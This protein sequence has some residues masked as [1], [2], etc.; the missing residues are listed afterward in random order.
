[1]YYWWT[2]S[3]C[4]GFFPSN[5]HLCGITLLLSYLFQCLFSFPDKTEA[6]PRSS[7]LWGR[8][9]LSP[10][11]GASLP[12][13]SRCC[14]ISFD[15]PTCDNFFFLFPIFKLLLSSHAYRVAFRLLLLSLSPSSLPPFA[16]LS[17]SLH[18][19]FFPSFL[20]GE[21][22]SLT[23]LARLCGGFSVNGISR[24]HFSSRFFSRS[25]PP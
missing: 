6:D 25:F 20:R 13:F 16:P 10:S 15:S 3:T 22:R 8:D 5:R 17:F 14:G 7:H 21:K 12:F 24:Y 18:F 1:M 4:S 9:L 19:F 2:S 23:S 11:R